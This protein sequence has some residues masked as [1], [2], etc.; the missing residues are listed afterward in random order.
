MLFA[1]LDYRNYK[2]R[3]GRFA[4]DLTKSIMGGAFEG[5]L[6]ETALQVLRPGDVLFVQTLGWPLSWLIMY[7]TKSEVSHVAFYLGDREIAHSTLGGVT[8]EPIEALFNPSTRILPCIW[9]MPDEKRLAVIRIVKEQYEGL[10]YGWIPALLKGIRI[11]TGRDWPYFRW[12]FFLDISFALMLIDLPLFL[13]LKYPVVA[14]LIPAYL[15]VIIFNWVLWKFWPLVFS[16]W[17]GKPCD[18]LRLLQL[19]E[20]SFLFDAFAVQ[21]QAMRRSHFNE[22]KHKRQEHP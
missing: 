3:E 2:R 13:F 12:V 21:Q 9:P 11:L 20:G 22:H 4:R 15:V 6:P 16:E 14:W 10:P 8:I 19:Q 17:T 1:L 7:L 5:S 18:L